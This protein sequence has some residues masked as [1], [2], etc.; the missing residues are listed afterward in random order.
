MKRR[1]HTLGE[2]PEGFAD[3]APDA[4]LIYITRSYT[5]SLHD[6]AVVFRPAPAKELRAARPSGSAGPAS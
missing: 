2:L 5:W 3:G 4:Y 6:D 1:K